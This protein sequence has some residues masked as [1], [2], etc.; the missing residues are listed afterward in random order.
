IFSV[1][2]EG[3]T[4]LSDFDI[5]ATFGHRIAGLVQY[6]ATVSD[7]I[8]DIAFTSNVENPLINA[9]EIMTNQSTNS[10]ETLAVTPDPLDF[11]L[12]STNSPAT[13]SLIT[14][15]NEGAPTDPP[16]TINDITFSG[17]DPSFFSHSAVLPI[18]VNPGESV[19]MPINFTPT[20]DVGPKSAD[21]TVVHSGIN[22]PSPIQVSAEIYEEGILSVSPDPLDFGFV[23][24]NSPT[25]TNFVNLSNEGV[26]SDPPITINAISF[27]GNDP[28][29]FSHSAVLPIIINPGESIEIPI[30]FIP[31]SDI[32]PKSADLTVAH[33][34]A[35]SPTSI[36]VSGE[37]TSLINPII[38]INAGGPE[39]TATDGGPN[40]EGNTA[41]GAVSGTDYS[42]TSGGSFTINGTD[43]VYAERDP[44]IP[45]YIDETTYTT[46][47]NS[48]RS[49]GIS[50]PPMVFSIPIPNGDYLVNLYFNNL[51]HGTSEPG[52]RIFS[53][54]VE[55][56]TIL[57]DFDI[58]ATFGHRIA[59]LVQYNATVSDGILDIAFTSNVENPMINAIEILTS[60]STP[61]NVDPIADQTNCIGGVA[62]FTVSATGGNSGEL[63]SY[64][65][66][67]QPDGINIE[68]NNGLIY[69]IISENAST[70]GINNDGIHLVEVTVS[71][72][73]STPQTVQFNWTVQEDNEAPT[74]TECATDITQETDTGLCTA[75]I[76]ITPPIATDNCSTTLTYSGTRSDALLLTDP[77]SV[78]V[79]TITWIVTDGAENSSNP[80]IQTIFVTGGS[81]TF[82]I[83][84][85]EIIN[86]TSDTGT[87]E[88]SVIITEPAS[89]G[90][91]GFSY[92]FEGIRSDGMELTDPYPIGS[93][94]IS[95]TAFDESNN[96]IDSCEQTIDV[97]DE[98]NPVIICPADINQPA[99]QGL[100]EATITIVEP[101]AND[102]CS[103]SFIY[104]GIRSD[105]LLL[106][107]PYSVGTTTISW[108]ATD[109]ANNISEPCV[110]TITVSDSDIPVISCPSDINQTT[111]PGL[112]EAT[113]SIVE[114]TAT[115]G[116]SNIF[117]FEGVRSDGLLLT[118]PFPLG[119][120]TISW[121]AN[122]EA[123]NTSNPCLQTVTVTGG[124]GDAMISCPIDINES[125]NIGLCEVNITITPP[126]VNGGCSNTYTFESLR[127]DGL[128]LTSPFPI[129]DT[130]ISWTALDESNNPIDSCEQTVTVTDGEIPVISCPADINQPATSGLC[131]ATI[132]IVE[133]TANDNCSTLFSIVGT[134]SDG[135][136]ITAPFPVGVTTISWTATDEAENTS[137]PCIQ[138]ITVTDGSNPVISC[139]SNINQSTDPGLCE[140]TITI[141]NPTASDD[142]SNTFSFDGTRSDGL[143]LTDPFPIGETTISWTANDEAGNTSDACLQ[144]I[145]VIDNEVPEINCPDDIVEFVDPGITE[146]AISIINP[147][148]SDN[149]SQ[150]LIFSPSRSDNQAITS[151]FPLGNTIITWV[152]IDEA[153]NSSSTCTQTITVTQLSAYNITLNV[154]LQGRSD[155][156]GNYF[157]SIYS[158]DNLT[159]P[160]YTF[161][162]TA[163]SSGLIALSSL[164]SQGDYV[165]LVK[166]PLY[167][168]RA[169]DASILSNSN[170][171]IPILLAGDADDNNTVSGY[172]KH[173]LRKAMNTSPGDNS[174]NPNTDFNGDEYIDMADFSLLSGN[175]GLSGETQYD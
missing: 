62:D 139:P 6:N 125:A 169:V 145:T 119:E 36:Q 135:L 72:P 9:I 55:G 132:S 157:I 130:T 34:G 118:D 123:E 23:S 174:Y 61:I 22:S 152:A 137:E 7:G 30:N 121:T 66:S 78:G 140:A 67:G 24:N 167:L 148:G 171:I 25:I 168:Q 113:I 83:I 115:D 45:D 1:D 29:F 88:A 102:N 73:S 163:N 70:G 108:T 122:D 75:L 87:C 159:T 107:A 4:I 172:D 49:V 15:S 133:P 97:T 33:S 91:C 65:I 150:N 104:E 155:Y 110:Q 8:L 89:S 81:E 94:T 41:S 52:Q 170:I 32:G 28:S 53:V 143:L 134:R 71:K 173:L 40:W 109:E 21:L 85:P 79:T 112:C 57:S 161:E 114:P 124:D 31:T 64:M 11:G 82:Q 90:G 74:I 46:V 117:T 142:C 27:S 19:E 95:W 43:L 129:G 106:T 63:F 37:I 105:G 162:E 141:D 12:V 146:I 116:C 48:E 98:E 144:T 136:L 84:C 111:D 14:L 151:P 96:P 165:I 42:V 76:S 126:T 101:T 99:E 5:A 100:C 54:D 164:I 3:Q 18:I 59:G 131:Q 17:N 103:T 156:S 128:E 149:C 166:H 39:V 92:T 153:G 147:T 2:V 47:M 93:T 20:S 154:S 35:N 60:Q 13:T 51:Y 68:P 77:F 56:Q 127:S 38:R 44:S 10:S 80:C 16:I 86:Q 160:A 58:A 175:F 26:S 50:S 69:G 138:T 158:T 120:T